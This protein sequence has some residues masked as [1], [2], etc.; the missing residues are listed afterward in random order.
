MDMEIP[1]RTTPTPFYSAQT[2]ES[3]AM[4]VT[5]AGKGGYASGEKRLA[6]PPPNKE[7]RST[8][9]THSFYHGN[10]KGY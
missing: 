7:K 10:D 9:C 6:A 3:I 5:V 1:Q 4:F 2:H 8:T